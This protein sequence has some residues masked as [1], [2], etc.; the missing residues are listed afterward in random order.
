MADGV[1]ATDGQPG[2]PLRGA[3]VICLTAIVAGVAIGFIGGAFRWC[4]QTAD[5]LRVDLVDWTH[6]L[7]GP[8]W[9]VPMA[10]AAAGATLAALIVRWVPLAAGSG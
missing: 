6:G 9:L 8:G 2:E 4:L 3:V 7:P 5:R 1:T 10:V